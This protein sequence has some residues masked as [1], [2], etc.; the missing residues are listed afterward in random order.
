MHPC[1]NDNEMAMRI[2]KWLKKYYPQNYILKSPYI[3]ALIIMA[4]C[5]GF[6]TIYKPLNVH[7]ARFFSFEF[8]MI[9]YCC[10]LSLPVIGL[11]KI[12][13]RIS[14][15]SN[16]SEWTILKEVISIALILL[17]MGITIYLTGFLVEIP[18][19]RWNLLTFLNS[20]IN[21]FLIGIIPFVFFTLINYRYLFV[22]DIVQDFK[23]DSN[24]SIPKQPEELVRIGSRLKKEEVSFY[25]SQFVYAESDGNYVIFH[26]DVDG[27]PHKKIVRN[28]INNIA[29]QLLAI[30]FL[31]RTHRAFIV[32][33]KKIRS[34]K[35]N[36][37]GYH[38]K[39]SGTDIEIPVSRQNTR[40]FDQIIKRYL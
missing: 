20:C 34:K 5:F 23:P 16:E 2:S 39:L 36:T 18:A 10:A 38:L 37:L 31:M 25:P 19:Q 35:G 9:I 30:P 12:L 1:K 27:Q 32:N 29:Q 11:V 21:A 33:L 7:E 13:R 15:F 28:S 22:T 24:P 40:D 3:G 17:G 14:Y 6:V 26:L 4:F 8:T